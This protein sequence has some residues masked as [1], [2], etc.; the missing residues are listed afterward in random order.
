MLK[1]ILACLNRC[2]PS[3]TE[4][5][6]AALIL[7]AA[8]IYAVI[9]VAPAARLAAQAQPS[10]SAIGEDLPV[11]SHT[12]SN[13]MRFLILERKAS[14]TVSF[15]VQYNVG[16]VNE[17]L[18]NTGIA[19]VLEHLLFKGSD[20]IGTR[21]VVAERALMRAMDNLHDSLQT[22]EPGL[23]SGEVE[24]LRGRLKEL[25]DQAQE[26][27]IPGEYDRLLSREGA[28]GLNA[29]TSYEATRYFVEL[30]SNRAELWFLLE[31]ERMANPVFREFFTEKD[32]V[33]EE[34]RMRIE[35]DPGGLLQSALLATAFQVHP[36]G[37]PVIGHTSDLTA[38][39]RSQVEAYFS[40]YYGARNAVVS[41]VGDVD[42]DQIVEWAEE[43]FSGI[44]PGEPPPPVTAVEPPQK[45]ERRVVVE[46]DAE[47]RIAMGWKTVSGLHEDGPALSMLAAVMTAGR[48]APV[49]RSLVT[50]QR[51]ATS[52]AAYTAPGFRY[53]R[54]FTISATPRSPHGVQEVEDALGVLVEEARVAPPD[55]ALLERI[56][57]QIRAGEYRRLQSNLGLASQLAEAEIT[58]GDW[59]VTF[60]STENLL[61][62]TPEDIQRVAQKYL[63][64]SQRTVAILKTVRP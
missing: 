9:L 31:S 5:A 32:V 48:S 33:A 38:M 49:Y 8:L 34:R 7:Y 25:E 55:S 13:G 61:A 19:H 12:L 50:E 20:E 2:R 46:Y 60:R 35:T 30:P 1:P 45:G 21:D 59:R 22:L 42:T 23:E 56:R 3:G 29:T 6:C 4:H 62:V 16:S 15:V 28:R 47:P 57:N 37:V 17:H 24:R 39:S 44:P 40:T 54:L 14:P 51:L 53:P 52:V 41:I 18:G 64:P 63:T 27:I 10:S 26:F 43:Y 58:H 11:V 36:Y